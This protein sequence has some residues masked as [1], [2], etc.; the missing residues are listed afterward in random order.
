[1]ADETP[2]VLNPTSAT[3]STSSSVAWTY[4]LPRQLE[5]TATLFDGSTFKGPSIAASD[6]LFWFWAPT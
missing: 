5:F 3:E 6:V 1:M 2:L 4:E